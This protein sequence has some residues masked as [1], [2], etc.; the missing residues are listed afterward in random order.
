MNEQSPTVQAAANL[1]VFGYVTWCLWSATNKL[2]ERRS[3]S[4]V[5]Y[6]ATR[7]TVESGT[8]NGAWSNGS[9][10]LSVYELSV[11][12]LMENGRSWV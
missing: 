2:P 5:G 6:P 12:L 9:R 10:R 3:S 8:V 4:R 7:K 1:V 11:R